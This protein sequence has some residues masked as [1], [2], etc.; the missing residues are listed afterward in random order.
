ML[1]FLYRLSG[2]R[3]SGVFPLD[4]NAGLIAF[5]RLQ[6]RTIRF[7]MPGDSESRL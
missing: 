3:A 5:S 2:I 1:T 6:Q 7:S 4:F